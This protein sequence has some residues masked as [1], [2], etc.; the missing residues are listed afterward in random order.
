MERFSEVGMEGRAER[1][2]GF[3]H[4]RFQRAPG[5]GN[6]GWLRAEENVEPLEIA[7]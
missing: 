1:G 6:D 4:L 7:E 5:Q 2:Y 3:D